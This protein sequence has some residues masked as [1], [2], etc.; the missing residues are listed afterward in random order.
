M[1]LHVTNVARAVKMCGCVI[2]VC[3]NSTIV[4]LEVEVE[5][6]YGMYSSRTI[7]LTYDYRS[8]ST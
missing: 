8:S 4:V 2:E 3:D 5:G 6:K 7:D 1:Q